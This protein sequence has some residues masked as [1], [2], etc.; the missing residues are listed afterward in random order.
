VS[1][2]KLSRQ[3]SALEGSL[4]RW[5]AERDKLLGRTEIFTID[6]ELDEVLTAFKLTFLNLCRHLQRHYLDTKME[7][8]TLIAHVLTLP[9]QRV[10]TRSTETIQIWR[11]SRERRHMEAVQR[12]CE[13]LT[14]KGLVRDKRRVRFEVVDKPEV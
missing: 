1:V 13:R 10:L 2:D 6:T 5:R 11:Q 12:A 14:A 4:A 8:E 3:Q 7:T 9:G